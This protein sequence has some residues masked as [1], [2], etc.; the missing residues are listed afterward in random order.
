MDQKKDTANELKLI[1]VINEPSQIKTGEDVRVLQPDSKNLGET[2]S[3]NPEVSEILVEEDE[4]RDLEE[5]WAHHSKSIPIGWFVLAG[6]IVCGL[7]GWAL[8][9]VFKAQSEIEEFSEE[10]QEI[11]IN[12]EKEDQEVKETLNL[13]EQCARGYFAADSI[14]SML[15]YVR[16]PER[17]QPLMEHYYQ[18]HDFNPGTFQQFK[19]IRSMGMES[20]SFVYGKVNLKDGR[21]RKAI[22]EQLPN[23]TFRVDWESDV[24]YQPIEWDT[25]IT[26]HPTEPVDMRVYVEPDN[27]FAYEF[28]DESRFNCFK[29]TTRGSDEHL[30][31]YTEKNSRADLDIQKILSKN[32]EYG[33]NH[34]TPMILR[35]RFPKNTQSKRS[36]WI[37]AVLAPRW[38]YAKPP[39]KIKKTTKIPTNHAATSS[40]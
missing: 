27:F 14:Q 38:I 31:A 35:L 18:T 37:D 1:K 4:F 34:K 36:V 25:Y 9:N 15:P 24:C 7:S 30:F 16:H 28:R 3:H 8:F 11:L 33:G 29:L 20:L 10:K 17:V 19:R 12:H 40:Q 22:I 39:P 5:D 32:A 23:G 6:M 26:K 2:K 21:S 13:M